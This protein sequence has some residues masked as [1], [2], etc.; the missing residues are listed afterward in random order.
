MY[1]K[2]GKTQITGWLGKVIA[3]QQPIR[4]KTYE[5]VR[6]AFILTERINS[7]LIIYRSARNMFKPCTKQIYLQKKHKQRCVNYSSLYII[8]KTIYNKICLQTDL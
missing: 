3:P 2:R 1:P 4:T 8:D 6:K 5:N 7:W